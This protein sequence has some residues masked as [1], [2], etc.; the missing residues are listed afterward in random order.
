[1]AELVL[2]FCL[3]GTPSSCQE[4]RPLV[5]DMSLMT[6]LVQGQQYAANWIADHPKWTLSG[7]RCE[8]N[9]P[10]QRQS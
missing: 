6:C 9:V 7:W 10:R 8:Q 3:A 2:I 1:M 5:A 4:E